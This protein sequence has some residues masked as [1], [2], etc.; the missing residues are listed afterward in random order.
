MTILE[1]RIT[2][3]TEN[4]LIGGDMSRLAKALAKLAK[5]NQQF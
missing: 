3:T 5:Q 2:E 1:I 4:F